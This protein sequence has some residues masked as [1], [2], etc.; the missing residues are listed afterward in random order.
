MALLDGREQRIIF[1]TEDDLM[2]LLGQVFENDGGFPPHL[3]PRDIMLSLN[4]NF[5]QGDFKVYVPLDGKAHHSQVEEDT[6]SSMIACNTVIKLGHRMTIIACNQM[7]IAL[8][9]PD[10]DNQVLGLR[11]TFFDELTRFG[12]DAIDDVQEFGQVPLY[13]A[14]SLNWQG[15]HITEDAHQA[16]IDWWEESPRAEVRDFTIHPVRYS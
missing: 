3:S 1:L 16:L 2:E 11:V 5:L 13:F 8:M 10:S 12:L 15:E 4:P 14:K 6:G 7:F 9:E